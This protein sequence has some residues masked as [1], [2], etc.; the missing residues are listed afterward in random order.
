[1]PNNLPFDTTIVT[2]WLNGANGFINRFT[3]NSFP[4]LFSANYLPRNNFHVVEGRRGYLPAEASVSEGATIAM[5]AAFRAYQATQDASWLTKGVNYA[6]SYLNY[7]YVEKTPPAT[8]TTNTVWISHW[9]LNAS[10]YAI[11]GKGDQSTQRAFNFGKFGIVI[12]FVNGVGT[13]PSGG[14]TQGESIADLFR[15]YSV[16]GDILYQSLNSP[17]KSG[18]NFTIN[19]WVSNYRLEGFNFR[20]DINGNRTATSESAGKI[21][22]G[23]AYANYTGNAK[24]IYTV[25]IPGN[26]PAFSLL[27]PYPCWH[28]PVRPSAETYLGFAVDAGWWG[29]DGFSDCYKYTGDTKWANAYTATKNTMIGCA[30]VENPSYYYK[31]EPSTNPFIAPGSQAIQIN[32]P[33]GYT[34]SRVTSEGAFKNYLRLD[35]AAGDVGTFPSFEVQNFIVQTAINSL[36]KVYVEAASNVTQ[37]LEVV[38]S[39]ATSPDDT[40]QEYRAYWLVNGDSTP[41]NITINYQ[42]FIKWNSSNV[43]HS[44][45]ADNPIYTYGS[46]TITASAEQVTVDNKL[47]IVQSVTV[48]PVGSSG[49]VAA[50]GLVLANFTNQPP[51]VRYSATT[52]ATSDTGTGWVIKITDSD[53]TPWFAALPNTNG[54]FNIFSGGW[55]KFQ[56]YVN[57]ANPGSGTIQKCEFECAYKGNIKL[58][59]CGGQPESVPPPST[60]YKTLLRS[61]VKT[62]QTLWVG[63]FKPLGNANDKLKYNP[64]VVPFTINVL[65]NGIGGFVKDSW[66]GA[67]YAGYQSPYHWQLWGYPDRANQALQ[68]LSDSQDA[69]QKQSG[70]GLKAPFMQ[71]FLWKYWD[72]ADFRTYGSMGDEWSWNGADPNTSWANYCYRPIESVARYLQLNPQSNIARKILT[73]FFQWMQQFLISS[74]GMPPTDI[75]PVVTPQA[76]YQEPHAAALIMRAALYA[77]VAGLLPE[78]TLDIIQRCFNY[79]QTQYVVAGTMR[80]SFSAGQPTFVSNGITYNEYFAF[81]HMEII[82]SISELLIY[83]DN[84]KYPFSSL[85]NKAGVFPNISPS[86]IESVT[87]PP[88]KANRNKFDDGNSQRILQ[89]FSGVKTEIVLVY[90]DLSADEAA[91][92]IN[93]WRLSQGSRVPF[94]LPSSIFVDPPAFVTGINSQGS[95]TYWRFSEAYNIETD[96]ATSVRGLYN[97]S[98]KI[99]SIIN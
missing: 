1:M 73:Y 14:S 35:I 99:V 46:G 77:N 16:D 64:G 67:P 83:K 48:A 91:I 42:S 56:N 15:V 79:L 45:I 4:Y 47:A 13:I 54:A 95:T 81:W 93:F 84:L 51:S 31:R 60:S 18:T 49:F 82:S 24:L 52:Q 71:V 68:F 87:L 98:I 43:W 28:N 10:N 92:F 86:R 88:F 6:E 12:S 8:S 3:R 33:N 21:V 63:D 38:L 55:G 74:G 57:K 53:G 36:V 37:I 96:F 22:L 7:F 70:I 76:N 26:I 25:W 62:A 78:L 80:G 72:T 89:S 44:L 40:S 2:T 50:C 30:V 5:V 85:L 94:V 34:A 69:Y 23:G 41:K 9:A 65:S 27:E 66:G 90:E 32:N 19:Y 39:L 29:A 58:Y 75:L 97:T 17:L 11:P 61:R 59:Y 20:Q